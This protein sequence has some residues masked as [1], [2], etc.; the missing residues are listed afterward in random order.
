MLTKEGCSHGV[1]TMIRV[2]VCVYACFNCFLGTL[3]QGL[4]SEYHFSLS[5]FHQWHYLAGHSRKTENAPSL[6]VTRKARQHTGIFQ[7]GQLFVL[8]AAS[9]FF[10]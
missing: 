1:D 7:M 4:V 6:P 8:L 9:D 10:P 3:T 5:L 2:C